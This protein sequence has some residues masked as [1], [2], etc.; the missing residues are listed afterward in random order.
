MK[1]QLFKGIFYNTKDQLFRFI[2]GMVHDDHLVQDLMQ[3]C[4]LKLWEVIDTIDTDK[5][6]LPFLYTVSRNLVIDHLRKNSRYY[7]VEDYG[8]VSEQLH[9]K[10]NIENHLSAK[11]GVERL[12]SL[13]QQMPERRREVFTLIKIRGYSYHETARLLKISTSTVEKHM[14]Q[15]YKM[16]SEQQIVTLFICALLAENIS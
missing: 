3:Q 14:H 13:L 16:L 6:V 7:F 11:A 2:R 10:G 12:H 1:E 15:A 8:L 4:Y 9:D 5:E